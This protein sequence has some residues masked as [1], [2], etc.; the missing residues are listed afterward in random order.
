MAM[1]ERLDVAVVLITHLNKTAGAQAQYRPS[2]SIAYRAACRANYLF[3]R[4][5]TDPAHRR[6]LICDNGNNLVQEVPTLTYTIE[7]CD[8]GP[9]V[10]WG[11]DPLSITADEALQAQSR[12]DEEHAERRE[13]DQWLRQALADGPVQANHLREAASDAGFT[14]DDVKRAKRRIRAQSERK[15]FGPGSKC[16]WHLGDPPDDSISASMERT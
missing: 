8:E 13:C 6:V 10:A 14:W 5:H 2:G 16:Y 3:V 1:A 4:D 15:G 11:A 9:V 12:D 7:S